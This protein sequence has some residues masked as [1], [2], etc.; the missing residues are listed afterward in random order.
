MDNQSNR[1]EGDFDFGSESDKS[2]EESK[3]QHSQSSEDLID[4]F[5]HKIAKS[6]TRTDDKI[7]INMKKIREAREFES[8]KK[9][10]SIIE[11]SPETIR[12]SSMKKTPMEKRKS[13]ELIDK[14]LEDADV[15]SV[16]TESQISENREDDAEEEKKDVPYQ[17]TLQLML[18]DYYEYWVED[19]DNNW[20]FRAL[21]R[22]TFG[23]PEYHRQIR[24][25]VADYIVSNRS[26][27]E[28]SIPGFDNYIYMM[29][30]FEVWGGNHELQAFSELYG[31]TIE[32]YDRITSTRARHIISC[33]VNSATI[34]LFFTGNHY[35]SLLPKNLHEQSMG[36]FEKFKNI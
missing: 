26:R 9:K 19:G 34:R 35:D 18:T 28:E 25:L 15:S 33:L 1:S 13:K 12:Q 20:M 17:N 3:S 4:T 2:K 6:N 11:V 30:N 16:D 27:F 36:V 32:I 31:V 23:S 22:S 5:K 7:V 14:W 8:Y 29:R 10:V 24:K 21:S